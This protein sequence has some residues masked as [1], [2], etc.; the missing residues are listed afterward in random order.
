MNA[1][2]P[3]SPAALDAADPLAAFAS[4]FYVEDPDLIYLLANSLGRLPLAAIDRLQELVTAEWGGRLIRGW[5]EGW[6]D[7]PQRL[8]DKAARLLGAQPGELLFADS[9]SVNLFK[10]VRA[11]LALRPGRRKVISDDLN[12]PSDLYILQGALSPQHTL[13]IVPSEDGI[14]GPVAALRAALDDDTALL[15]LSHTA[16]KSAYVYDMAAVTRLAHEAGA[17]ALWDLSHSAG[18]LELDL[19][20]AQADFAVGCSYKYLS[21]GPGAPAFLYVRREHQQQAHNPIPGWMGQDNPFA[22]DLHYQPAPGLRRFLTGTPAILSLAAVEPGLDLL[23][24]A[25]M[26]RLRAK[27]VAQS[28]YLLDLWRE[29]LQPLGFTLCS[30]LEAQRR[31]SHIAL[32]HPEALRIGQALRQEMNLLPDFR[33]PDIL[34]L[35]IGPLYTSYA[36]LHQA[37][38]RIAHVVTARLYLKYPITPPPV[39]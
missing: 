4:R 21:G 12:F 34:R 2:R 23:L 19:Q 22:F 29:T 10:A 20:A 15:A 36:Q 33:A 35:A 28:S 8:G 16:F 31:G 7:L 27:S 3:A 13:H 25:G 1:P 24:E 26:S 38:Q 32:A 14:H 30:P 39:T 5:N 9:T 18:A 17:L 37:V 6:I 11:A